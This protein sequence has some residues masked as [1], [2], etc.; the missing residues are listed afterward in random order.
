LIKVEGTWIVEF[1]DSIVVKILI[2]L[3][4]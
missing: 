1:I 2:S 4:G 3:T